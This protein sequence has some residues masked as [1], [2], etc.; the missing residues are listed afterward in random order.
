MFWLLIATALSASSLPPSADVELPLVKRE[1][2]FSFNSTLYINGHFYNVQILNQNAEMT[3]EEYDQFLVVF[4]C[5]L[6]TSLVF[7]FNQ[8][9]ALITFLL[10]VYLY[11]RRREVIDSE[12]GRNVAKLEKIVLRGA[13]VTEVTVDGDNTVQTEDSES[14]AIKSVQSFE[15]RHKN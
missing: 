2:P 15:I 8:V 7:L 14:V 11:R 12:I 10:A 6:V 3:K 4:W 5:S 9:W 1:T 13:R